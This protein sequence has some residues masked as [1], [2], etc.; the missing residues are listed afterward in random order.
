MNRNIE[1]ALQ[2]NNI[3]LKKVGAKFEQY[4]IDQLKKNK[5]IHV[6]TNKVE[7]SAY[8][9]NNVEFDFI[10]VFDDYL[11]LIECKSLLTPYDDKELSDRRKSIYEGVEQV[12]RRAEI[13]RH[14]WNKIVQLVNIEMP[15][16]PYPEEKII[17]IVCTDIY[18]FTTLIIDGV[19]ITDFSILLKYFNNPLIRKYRMNNEESLVESQKNLWKNGTPNPQELM[20]Y[21]DRPDA[22][23]IFSDCIH[24][25]Q[26]PIIYYKGE[27]CVIF[28]D[29]FLDQDPFE[30][31]T[32][33]RK[34]RNKIYPNE[35]CPCGSGKKYKKCCGKNS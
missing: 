27:N 7:F 25:H 29:M 35:K 13:V 26:K 21:L 5:Y 28:K 16:E 9:G 19:R 18:D 32:K 12:L 24:E 34:K 15:S 2:R 20:D 23:S 6:N 14:D 10:G 11:V 33:H 3:D 22:V 1:K 8:D 30:E 31:G 4:I 17:K